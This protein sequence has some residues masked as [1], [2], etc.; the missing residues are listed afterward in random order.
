MEGEIIEHGALRPAPKKDWKLALDKRVDTFAGVL[1]PDVNPADFIAV[2]KRA[3]MRDDK[4]RDCIERNPAAAFSAFLDC[5]R[6]GL[7]PDGREAHIDARKDKRM[8]VTAAYMPMRRGLVKML[9]KSGKV[10]SVDLHVVYEGDEFEAN[11]S[12]GASIHHVAL[13]K[14]RKPIA[15]WGRVDLSDGGVVRGLMWEADINRRR[16]CAKTKMVWDKWPEEMWK[17]TLLHNM[18]KDL[19]LDRAVQTAIDRD[20]EFYDLNKEVA[21]PTA[22]PER[23][24]LTGALP[25]PKRERL[26][27]GQ[28]AIDAVTADLADETP[29]DY[30]AEDEDPAAQFGENWEP[31]DA[32]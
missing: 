6:D 29:G 24:D 25:A 11:L 2:C 23:I 31:K 17:K 27:E 32:A 26:A 1:P 19:P 3:V 8:G 22:L 28:A 9:Y 20:N 16:A 7:I 21:K 14:S 15:V 10:R 18:G 4:L 30:P 13:G 5:A 12:E